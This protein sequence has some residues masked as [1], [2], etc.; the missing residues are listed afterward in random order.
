MVHHPDS[1]KFI[2]PYNPVTDNP[3]VLEEVPPGYKSDKEKTC[4]FRSRTKGYLALHIK[5]VHSGSPKNEYQSR[6]K[7]QGKK[8]R[9]DD[10]IGVERKNT[11]EDCTRRVQGCSSV[12]VVLWIVNN[13]I[14]KSV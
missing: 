6:G 7:R 1:L 3:I 12:E 10:E 11:R 2:C 9:D 8:R 4:S 14:E 5:N 13:I